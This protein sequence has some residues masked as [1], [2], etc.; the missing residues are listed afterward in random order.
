MPPQA[1][2]TLCLSGR[3]IC[4]HCGSNEEIISL[5]LE[6]QGLQEKRTKHTATACSSCLRKKSGIGISI[7]LVEHIRIK[8]VID[9]QT[10]ARHRETKRISSKREAQAAQDIG[11]L[12]V[13]GSGSGISKG[14]A[15]NS[16]WMV[17]DKYT[18]GKSFQL[19]RTVLS[20][21]VEQASKTGR[22]PVIRVGLADGT[23]LAVCLWSDLSE[24][25]REDT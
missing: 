23:E 2:A 16:N 24:V 18:T 22:K 17:E 14:D 3:N 21:A 15:R 6:V 8:D 13:S 4:E 25:I 19:R 20:K 7:S 11:G 1:I 5:R 9:L 12:T 10:K